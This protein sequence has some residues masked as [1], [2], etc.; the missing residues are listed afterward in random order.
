MRGHAHRLRPADRRPRAL[1]T[2][3]ANRLGDLAA[4]QEWAATIA[5][6]APLTL[7]HYKAVFTWRTARTRRG[8]Q[9][10]Q[11]AMMRAWASEDLAEGRAARAEKRAPRFIGAD[12]AAQPFFFFFF[13]SFFF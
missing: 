7:A 2:G 6:P 4:A 8:P 11:A 12:A 5:E 3:F 13:L 9:E 10:R 1:A